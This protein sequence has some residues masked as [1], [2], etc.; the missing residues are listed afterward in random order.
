MSESTEPTRRFS[1]GIKLENTLKKRAQPPAKPIPAVSQTTEPK[2]ATEG[3]S[4]H[5]IKVEKTAAPP[6]S[7][8]TGGSRRVPF[9]LPVGLNE[10]LVARKSIDGKSKTV[11][12]LQAIEA[13]HQAGVLG[14]QI[15]T[16]TE[17]RSSLFDFPTPR[18]VAEGV[19]PGEIRVSAG[20]CVVI[21]ELVEKYTLKT[22]T[23]LIIRALEFHLRPE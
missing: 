17:S 10:A 9:N 23:E 15:E 7:K 20:N 3:A 14:R 5:P 19:V 8:L 12:I 1:S 18:G 6:K 21:D 4:V 22:R 16:N 2:K 13:A 11:V